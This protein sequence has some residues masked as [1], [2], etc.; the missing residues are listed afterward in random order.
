VSYSKIAVL[1]VAVITATTA[2][3]YPREVPD[4]TSATPASTAPASTAP[5]ST[6]PAAT[7]AATAGAASEADET[8]AL[9]AKA[10][11]A[12]ANAKAAETATRTPSATK[13]EP[14]AEAR[15]KASEFG[16]HAEIY[17]GKT[18]F[19]KQDAALGSRLTSKRCMGAIQFED[20]SVQLKI[21]RDMMQS[22]T[23]CQG[24]KVLGG[25]CGGL[26]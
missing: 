23:A 7:A 4:S 13:I 25:P 16:F 17:D 20:Y 12:A 10:N 15:K 24:G 22:K 8:A 19:C 2:S 11:A 21:A 3:G 6:A 26:P 5:A 9:I 1:I 14:S 18:M